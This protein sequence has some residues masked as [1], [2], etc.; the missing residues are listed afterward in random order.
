[1]NFLTLTNPMA[2]YAEA[3]ARV[4]DPLLIHRMKSAGLNRAFRRSLQSKSRKGTL[5]RT[6][7]PVWLVARFMSAGDG[8]FA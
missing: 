6:D 8:A 5:K 1:M 7:M 3:L 2:H 4:A